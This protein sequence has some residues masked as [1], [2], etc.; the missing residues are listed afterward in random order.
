MKIAFIGAGKMAETLISHLGRKAEIFAADR[1]KTRLK[2]IAAQYKIKPVANNFEAFAAAEIIVLAV[3]PQNMAEVLTEIQSLKPKAQSKKSKLIISIAAGMPLSYLER[4]LPGYPVV[5]AMPNNPCLVGAGITALVKGKKAGGR[6]F[7]TAEKIFQSVGQTVRVP[8]E[9]MDAV[10]GLSG[11]GPAFVY[12]VA[13]ALIKGGIEAGL[14]NKLAGKLALQTVIGAAETLKVSGESPAKL[15]GMVT[16][17]GGTTMEGLAV[18]EKYNS[19]KAFISAVQAAA[20]KSK[21]LNER[22]AQ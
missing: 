7:Q 14:P 16:S 6:D 12:Q 2:K 21:F 8:E 15:R 22:W 17:P 9:Y 5:R 3:K 18:L 11:S 4:K 20:A 10:T 1:D 13:E 19:E